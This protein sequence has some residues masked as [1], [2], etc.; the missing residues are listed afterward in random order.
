[1]GKTFVHEDKMLLQILVYLQR[2]IIKE[3]P[4]KQ[5][6]YFVPYQM[7]SRDGDH[8]ADSIETLLVLQTILHLS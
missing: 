8:V 3:K 7:L 2:F 1:M 4:K 6:H 5:G